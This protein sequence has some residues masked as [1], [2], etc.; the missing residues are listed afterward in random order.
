MRLV[1]RHAKRWISV[2]LFGEDSMA[3]HKEDQ[4]N[5]AEDGARP[6]PIGIDADNGGGEEITGDKDVDVN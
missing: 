6:V 1:D 4:H 3:S 2:N 5:G